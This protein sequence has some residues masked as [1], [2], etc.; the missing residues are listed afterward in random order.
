M[1]SATAAFEAGLCPCP[2]CRTGVIR[3]SSAR[4]AA[5]A[6]VLRAL[7]LIQ[8][9]ALDEGSTE[10]LSARLGLSP[11]HLRRLFRKHV[12][13]SPVAVAQAQ[14]LHLARQLIEETDWP[15]TDVALAS[16]YGSVRRFNAAIRSSYRCS[17]S[18]L[19][20]RRGTVAHRP[21]PGGDET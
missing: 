8:E 16:G 6:K 19:R 5:A 11:R 21:R 12:G 9:G 17:P 4:T 13:T 3:G 15:M 1:N 2:Q 18:E 10:E 7:S 14:R 20:R